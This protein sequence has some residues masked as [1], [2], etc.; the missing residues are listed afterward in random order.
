M[1]VRKAIIIGILP[2][3]IF[4]CKQSKKPKQPTNTPEAQVQQST[5]STKPKPS[6]PAAK[7]QNHDPFPGFAKIIAAKTIEFYRD[8]ENQGNW[9]EWGI[10]EGEK[11]I[12]IW[13]LP[14]SVDFEDSMEILR[15]TT[16]NLARLRLMTLIEN[17]L[18]YQIQQNNARNFIQIIANSGKTVNQ[19]VEI[20]NNKYSKKIY[21]SD[22]HREIG[23]LLKANFIMQV[24]IVTG[25]NPIIMAHLLSIERGVKVAFTGNVSLNTDEL[26]KNIQFQFQMLMDKKKTKKPSTQYPEEYFK[27]EVSDFIDSKLYAYTKA[28]IF[29][30]KFQKTAYNQLP[31]AVNFNHLEYIFDLLQAS[32]TEAG[33]YTILSS[34]NAIKAFLSKGKARNASLDR[35]YNKTRESAAILI[36]PAIQW[37]EKTAAGI[38]FKISLGLNRDNDE[39]IAKNIFTLDLKYNTNLVKFCETIEGDKNKYKNKLVARMRIYKKAAERV[40]GVFYTYGEM[41][42]DEARDF[43]ASEANVRFNH[44]VSNE[45][46]DGNSLC[47]DIDLNKIFNIYSAR[48]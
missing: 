4:N 42:G 39:L 41:N 30:Q 31:E 16:M 12:K 38:R 5:T 21:E 11:K 34:K 17:S 47:F 10:D 19:L 23:K 25:E 33:D 35:E 26:S 22:V 46:I 28:T 1:N 27:E 20:I 3:F 36:Y 48:K 45:R 44:A 18:G 2:L 29:I 8:I 43:I 6:T 40:A 9:K 24:N 7:N 15:K 32:I 37:I 14:P 13:V